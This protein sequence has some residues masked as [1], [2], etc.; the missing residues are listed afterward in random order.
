M[1]T[2]NGY[3]YNYSII[4]INT[5]K[6]KLKRIKM[7][8]NVFI[9]LDRSGSMAYHWDETIGSL[10]GYVENLKDTNELGKTTV[11]I[12]D[13]VGYDIIREAVEAGKFVPVDGTEHQPR[14]ATPLYDSF[15]KLAKVVDKART[16]KNMFIIIT[17]G[18]ENASQECNKQTCKDW[19][20][21]LEK[22]GV[23]IVFLGANFDNSSEAN[24]MGL[25]VGKAMEMSKGNYGHTM[26]NLANKTRAYMS[27]STT[28]SAS[29]ALDFTDQERSEARGES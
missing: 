3:F 15:D 29:A 7:K 1:G 11:A 4:D 8:S 9:L 22:K 21:K 26:T 28:G 18:M 12:F 25:S 16:K 19:I 24:Q 14:G 5:T 6:T 17:D 2:F 13:S 23:G 10:N 27:A 20:E